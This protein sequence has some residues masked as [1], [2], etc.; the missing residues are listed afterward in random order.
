METSLNGITLKLI[1]GDLTEQAVDA[2]VNATTTDFDLSF[3]IGQQILKKGGMAILSAAQMYVP[4]EEGQVFLTTA[5]NLPA[6]HIIHAV[7]PRMGSGHERGKLASAVW[8]T[9]RLVVQHELTSVAFPP[10]STGTLGY[11][12]EGCAKVM[13]QKIVDFTFEDTAPLKLILICLENPPVLHI[14]EQAFMAEVEAA[15]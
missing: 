9:L 8:N 2:I 4:A 14:F 5:G 7:G 10:I 6:K 1:H 11:P 3:G 12:V 13:A 15:R